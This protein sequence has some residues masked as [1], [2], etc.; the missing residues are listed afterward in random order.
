MIIARTKKKLTITLSSA[1]DS[2]ELQRVIDYIKY[3]ESTSKAK[4]KQKEVDKLADEINAS[5]WA[6][7]KKRFIK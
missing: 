3:L 6:K 2:Y 4:T 5:W 1:V 7:N